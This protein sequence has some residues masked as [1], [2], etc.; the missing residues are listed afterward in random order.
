M[1]NFCCEKYGKKSELDLAVITEI[2]RC[3]M[4]NCECG[5][6]L[7]PEKEQYK[8]IQ[9]YLNSLMSYKDYKIGI[10]FVATVLCVISFYFKAYGATPAFIAFA[11]ATVFKKAEKL[12]EFEDITFKVAEEP[13]EVLN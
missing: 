3:G 5:V 7:A 6:V 4:I 13:I 12:K 2:N 8:E 1:C 11:G 10:Y 9:N